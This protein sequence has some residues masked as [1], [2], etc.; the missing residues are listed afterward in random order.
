MG[1]AKIGSGTLNKSKDPSR[2]APYYGKCA[3]T[4]DGRE[5][6]VSI[7]AWVKDGQN[8]SKFFS[9]AFS[10]P[11]EDVAQSCPQQ[12]QAPDDEVPF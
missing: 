8:G 10:V 3:I 9:L 6:Q 2:G 12:R 5:H 1:W 11:E 4:I 7:G